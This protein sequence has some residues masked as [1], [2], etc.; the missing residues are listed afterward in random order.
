MAKGLFDLSKRFVYP[1]VNCN[2]GPGCR[3]ELEAHRIGRDL[4]AFVFVRHPE[5]D[6]APTGSLQPI[7]IHC[8]NSHCHIDPITKSKSN[9][10]Q[11]IVALDFILE[12]I[13]STSGR[14]DA[15]QIAI[16]TP[17]TANVDV[18]KSVRR[19]P[20]YAALASMKPAKTIYSFQG[21]E[22]DIIIA[23]MATTKQAG[24]GMTT[25]E[26]HLNVML[27]RHRSGLI[28]VGDIN[29]TGRLDD[30]RS[31]RHGHV[32]LDKFQVVGAN[33]EVSWVNGTMLRSVHQALWESKRVITV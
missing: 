31:K 13:S 32:G 11:V 6:A 12:F 10:D 4:E 33:G 30:E 9:R 3:I 2:Y 15:S 26:H 14:V 22:S 8:E 20:K 5:L 7:F 27:S 23:I 17:Y 25:D 29:V 24:P 21:Q 1:D 18:I 16:I 28:I 19:G